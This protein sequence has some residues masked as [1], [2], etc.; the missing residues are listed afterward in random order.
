[1]EEVAKVERGALRGSE[2][3]IEQPWTERPASFVAPSRTDTS[4]THILP[5]MNKKL[6][7]VRVSRRGTGRS[8][9]SERSQAERTSGKSPSSNEIFLPCHYFDYI[10]GTGTGG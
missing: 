7:W 10:V 4:A 3:V 6:P 8:D 1:M 5:K 9:D 2:E